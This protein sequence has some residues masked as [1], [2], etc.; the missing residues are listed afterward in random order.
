MV[1]LP[2]GLILLLLGL[3]AALAA[4]PAA[5]AAEGSKQVIS[6]VLADGRLSF[7]GPPTV[8]QGEQLEIVN[9]TNPL[10]VGPHTF[11]L[12]ERGARPRTEAARRGCFTPG[13][14]CESIALWHGYDPA[15]QRT[16]TRLAEA[17]AP[18][19][20]TLGNNRG[21]VGDSWLSGEKTGGSRISQ[22]VSAAPGTRLYF[23][24]AIH[25]W[26]QGSIQVTPGI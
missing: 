17:G 14:L 21:K 13:H 16:T 24:C 25:P 20:S 6:I 11:S 26:M 8:R 12:V 5:G 1:P 4:A 22:E 2:R 18:G 19:W 15:T 7:S 10:L 9:K 3:G 23:V